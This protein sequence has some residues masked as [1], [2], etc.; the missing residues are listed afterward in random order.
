MQLFLLDYKQLRLSTNHKLNLVNFS[1]NNC[2]FYQTNNKQ[3]FLPAV[4]SCHYLEWIQCF[5]KK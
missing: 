1:L 3:T 4:C 2:V 5:L